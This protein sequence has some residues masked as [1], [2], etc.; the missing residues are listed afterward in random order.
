MKVDHQLRVL[1]VMGHDNEV[2]DAISRRHFARALSIVP[3]LVFDE[4]QPP[5]LPMGATKK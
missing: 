5:Q 4:F 3:Q 1:H 2:A